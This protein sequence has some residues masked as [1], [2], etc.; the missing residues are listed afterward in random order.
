MKKYCHVYKNNLFVNTVTYEKAHG[1]WRATSQLPDRISVVTLTM[2]VVVHKDE[3]ERG[4]YS[5]IWS[6]EP[7]PPEGD[8]A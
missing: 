3:L 5:W 6:S 8:R 1:H 7:V 2:G 4:G